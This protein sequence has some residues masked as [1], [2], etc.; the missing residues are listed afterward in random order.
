MA[1][2][3]AFHP[4]TPDRWTD[5]ERLF[6]PRG[7]YAG[8]WCMWWRC[9]R[10][11]FSANGNEGNRR[12]FRAIVQSGAV[13]GLLAYDADEPVGWC[14]VA[15]R[16]SYPSLLRSRTLRSDDDPPRWSIVCLF[17]ARPWRGRGVSR[18]LVHA[19]V[20]HVRDAGGR[21]IEA[22][23]TEP[24]GRRLAPVSSYMGTPEM[25]SSARFRVYSRPSASRVIMRRSV[26]AGRK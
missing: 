23:P 3:L 10:R 11:E 16:D 19:A 4:L 14:S 12:Q 9:S 26:R 21:L 8:C 15:P 17:V 2:T 6:G 24:A 13:P 20:D 22:Y 7:A 1:L 18:A 25:F 5:L